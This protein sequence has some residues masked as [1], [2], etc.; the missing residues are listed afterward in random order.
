MVSTRY[1][2]NNTIYPEKLC[3][4]HFAPGGIVL[5]EKLGAV[6]SPLPKTFILF[7]TKICDFPYS[8]YDLKKELLLKNVHSSRLGCK[9]K[10]A[11]FMAKIAKSI[12]YL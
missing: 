1:W 2:G 3:S 11:L 5:P 10:N 6:C 12:S 8:I 7:M 9:R 4:L